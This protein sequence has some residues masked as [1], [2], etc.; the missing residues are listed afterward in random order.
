MKAWFFGLQPRERWI[1]GIG[2]VVAGAAGVI[3]A[4]P[5]AGFISVSIRH[6]REYREIERLL[7]NPGEPSKSQ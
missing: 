7:A 3:I 1:V 5:A 4:I 6:W 2:A